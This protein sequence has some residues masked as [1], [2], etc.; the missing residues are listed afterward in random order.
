MYRIKGNILR[1]AWLFI[2]AILV[3][4]EAEVKGLQVQGLLGLQSKSKLNLDKI[5]RIHLRIRSGRR[6]VRLHLRDVGL[7]QH[8]ITRILHPQSSVFKGSST[9][10]TQ[11]DT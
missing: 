5:V 8:C 9:S 10:S 2:T 11:Y 4:W 3:A 7:A 1:N 6:R